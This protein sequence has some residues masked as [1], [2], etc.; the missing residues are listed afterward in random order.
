MTMICLR[1]RA[2]REAERAIAAQL[3]RYGCRVV[4]RAPGELRVEFPLADDD[5]EALIETRLY[6]G[7]RIHSVLSA[8]PA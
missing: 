7:P 8:Q 3:E 4:D 1:I 5:R 2:E 6:L